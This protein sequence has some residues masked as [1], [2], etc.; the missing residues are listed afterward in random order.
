M[1]SPRGYYR[2]LNSLNW[3]NHRDIFFKIKIDSRLHYLFKEECKLE[4]EDMTTVFNN[5]IAKWT[6]RR[7]KE[8][9]CIIVE[10]S[11]PKV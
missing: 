6:I 7:I 11:K 2:F 9:N 1:S 4:H 8:R 10:K 5:I 3:A